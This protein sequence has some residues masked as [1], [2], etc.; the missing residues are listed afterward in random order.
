MIKT[1]HFCVYGLFLSYCPQFWGFGVIY[2][3]HDTQYM[4]ERYDQKLVV[5]AFM[6]VSVSYYPHFCSSVEIYK[7][8]D[9][10]YIL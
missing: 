9:S 7:E 10:L 2:K 5:F 3:V 6:D 8:Y 4:F 1:R